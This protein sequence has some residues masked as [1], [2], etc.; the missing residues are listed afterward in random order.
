[1]GG[2]GENGDGRSSEGGRIWMKRERRG[3]TGMEGRTYEEMEGGRQEKRERGRLE[4]RE[5]QWWPS[6]YSMLS[7][8][9][10]RG[11]SLSRSGRSEGEVREGGK[12]RGSE[13]GRHGEK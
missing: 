2:K 8:L 5:G 3:K 1:M 9:L 6:V 13:E 7:V 11:G 4:E 12:Q 10:C